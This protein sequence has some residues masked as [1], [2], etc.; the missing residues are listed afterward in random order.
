MKKTLLICLIL[1]GCYTASSQSTTPTKQ[2][3]NKTKTVVKNPV[4]GETKNLT[5]VFEGYSEGDYP[6]L[7][8]KD[9]VKNEDYDFESI[10]ES[11]LKTT[12][13]LL[14]DNDAAFGYKENPDYLGKTFDVVLVWKAAKIADLDGKTVNTK[15]WEIKSLK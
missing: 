9:K 7:G 11:I 14:T 15:R 12:P 3:T 1:V 10:D 2:A 8:L 13:I 6:H 4:I 5:M